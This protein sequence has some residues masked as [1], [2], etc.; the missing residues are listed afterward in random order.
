MVIYGILFGGIH[1]T[2]VINMVLLN[3][4]FIKI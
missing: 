3:T 4:D 1:P 2:N